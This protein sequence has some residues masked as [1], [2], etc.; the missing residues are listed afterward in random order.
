MSKHLNF[1]GYWEGEAVYE[2][3]QCQTDQKFRFDD[4]EEAKDSKT[5]RKT[6][7]E[8]HGWVMAKV[9]GQWKEFCCE[10]CRNKYIRSNTL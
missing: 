8:N 6:L 1:D 9:N 10:D 5:H 4:E 2:C 7:R 3:D